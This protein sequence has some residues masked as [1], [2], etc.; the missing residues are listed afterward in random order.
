MRNTS[1]VHVWQRNYYEHI[2]RDENELFAIRQ[3]IHENPLK[4][5]MDKENPLNNPVGANLAY[6]QAGA[7]RPAMDVDNRCLSDNTK[8]MGERR[9]PLHIGK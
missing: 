2:I 1:G 4:W 9:S 5:E 6:R 3:Y 8:N 7:V